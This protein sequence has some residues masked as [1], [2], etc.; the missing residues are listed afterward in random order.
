MK[1][2]GCLAPCWGFAQGQGDVCS[3]LL[4]GSNALFKPA[5]HHFSLS[6]PEH[7]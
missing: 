5:K 7:G 3:Q 4:Q 2:K 1:G 6:S